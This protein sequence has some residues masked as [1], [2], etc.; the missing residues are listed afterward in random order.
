[1][2][3]FFYFVASKKAKSLYLRVIDSPNRKHNKKIAEE[4]F[5]NSFLEHFYYFADRLEILNNIEIPM[6]MQPIS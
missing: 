3:D 4:G 6:E 2:R 5:K 1:M